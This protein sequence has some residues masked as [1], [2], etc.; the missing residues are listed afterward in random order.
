[1]LAVM[2][3]RLLAPV[4]ML[5]WQ[6][7]RFSCINERPI[8]YGFALACLGRTSPNTVLDVGTGMSAW[9]RVLADCGFRVTAMDN[10]SDYWARGIFNRHYHVVDDDITKPKLTER[11]D[12]VTCI[13]VLEHIPNHQE[14]VR[15]VFGL[16]N[17]GG[18]AVLSFPY[19]ERRYVSNVYE[20]EGAGY[21]KDKPYVCQ[22][23]S[24]DELEGWM[25]VCGGEI[26]GEEYYEVFSGELWTFG[27]RIYP[28][29]RTGRDGR[30][31]LACLLVRKAG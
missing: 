12:F 6:K 5:E 8:E 31:Q 18:H 30:H 21:G 26:V 15:G 29:R 1:M 23:F 25:K 14:A 27:E 20:L 24:R 7:P 13:S 3:R 22:V 19:N 11:F 28:P 4:L 2:L 16:V 9:P 17:D 10:V